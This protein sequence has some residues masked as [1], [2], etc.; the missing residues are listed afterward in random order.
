LFAT[1]DELKMIKKCEHDWHPIKGGLFRLMP[2][3]YSKCI[4]CG[5]LRHDE[6]GDVFRGI[7]DGYKTARET[8]KNKKSMVF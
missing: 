7:K 1:G 3:G 6:D 8:E 5:L 4:K 2:K